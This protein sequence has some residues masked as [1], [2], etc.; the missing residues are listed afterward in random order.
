MSAAYA[1][2]FEAVFLCEHPRGPKM[3]HAAATKYMRKSKSY[4]QKWV[5]RY[6]KTK[7][8][9]DLQDRGS[10]QKFSKRDQKRI[11]SL[12]SKNPTL[13]LREGQAKLREKGLDISYGTIRQHLHNNNL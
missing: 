9:D 4:V 3:S 10:I 8:V 1:S 7:T 6:E 5:Q 12:Y 11:I 13:T 2:R